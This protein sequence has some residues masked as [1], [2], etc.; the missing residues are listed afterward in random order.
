MSSLPYFGGEEIIIKRPSLKFTDKKIEGTFFKHP[1]HGE[2]L[3][4]SYNGENFYHLKKAVLAVNVAKMLGIDEKVSEQLLNPNSCGMAQVSTSYN[5]IPVDFDFME[6]VIGRRLFEK[7]SEWKPREYACGFSLRADV[8]SIEKGE[9]CTKYSE[10]LVCSIPDS[11]NENS[12]SIVK[13]FSD[14]FDTTLHDF[15]K[16]PQLEHLKIK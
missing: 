8:S 10:K 6:F 2:L 9:V 1:Y 7:R 3:D 13:L 12:A 11:L 5:N 14:A 4:K 15:S 16:L